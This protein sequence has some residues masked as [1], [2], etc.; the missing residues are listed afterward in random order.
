MMS[1]Q[2]DSVWKEVIEH[3]FRDCMAFFFPEIERDIDWHK[4]YEFL[5]K[6]LEK[7]VRDSKLGKRLADKLVK[8]FLQ[9]GDE[10]W[11][12]IHIEVQG[13]P[14]DNFAERV[15]IYNYRI[16]DRYRHQ[17]I[18]LVI[19]TDKNK[20]FRPNLYQVERWGFE[21]TFRFRTIKLIDY[22]PQWE[23]L[24][25]NPNPFAIVVMAQLKVLET[26]HSD[27]LLLW[28]LKLVRMLYER[29]YNRQQ[30]IELFRFIDWLMIL[31]EELEQSFVE[32]IHQYEEEGKMPY[33]TSIERYGRREGLKEGL[34][35]GLL[36]AIEVA[37]ALRFGQVGLNLMPDIQQ[38]K[39]VEQLRVIK[40][41][42][43][44]IN[45]LSE[46]YPLL[47]IKPTQTN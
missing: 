11:L 44:E 5:D 16:F 10:T 32:T 40:K 9:N 20:K 22:T 13:S 14:E 6:E 12:L 31:P 7:I 34:Q 36:E 33:V 2:Q 18:S 42:L 15:Y 39:D 23:Q 47:P 17:V 28:K 38:V 37:L 43:L 45:N 3:Y 26:R 27:Q 1:S 29:G 8:V 41:A 30:V 46:I 4:G 35:K 19:L 25:S 24:E 21:L